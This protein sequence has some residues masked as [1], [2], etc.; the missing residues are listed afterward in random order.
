[1]L[2]FREVVTH[3]RQRFAV[4]RAMKI[5]RDNSDLRRDAA[6]AA[7]VDFTCRLLLHVGII[8]TEH[9][10]RGPHHVHRTGGFRR[11]LNEIDYSAGQLALGPQRAHEFI[12]L[13]AVRQFA[14][15]QKVNHLLVT[16]L[17]GQFVDV[18]AGVNELA[19]IANDIAQSRAVCDDAFESARN[20]FIFLSCARSAYPPSSPEYQR[21]RCPL[22]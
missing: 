9:G 12:K 11:R 21:R 1:M 8:K 13:A 22:L 15:P 10:N 5:R 18:V 19:F 4:A 17:A 3:R 16:H 14:F 20:H 7:L 6:R 2:S